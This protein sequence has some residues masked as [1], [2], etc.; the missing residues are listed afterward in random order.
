MKLRK[1]TDLKEDLV[2][3]FL[4]ALAIAVVMAL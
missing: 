2:L 4:T 1:P 3:L